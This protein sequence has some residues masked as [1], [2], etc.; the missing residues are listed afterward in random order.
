MALTIS[1][2]PASTG[3][4]AA[5]VDAGFLI[6]ESAKV[7]GVDPA[8]MKPNPAQLVQVLKGMTW[9]NRSSLLR[10]YWYD[11]IV[12]P[13]AGKY[14]TMRAAFDAIEAT[15]GV[16]LRLGHLSEQKP[17]WQAALKRAL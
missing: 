10:V 7:L 1:A 8:A 5:F 13:G 15:P 17:A 2:A 9:D 6:A 14:K 4:H 11:A 12:E 3:R 16:R